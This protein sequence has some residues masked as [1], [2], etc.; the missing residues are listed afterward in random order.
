MATKAEVEQLRGDVARL[1]DELTSHKLEFAK[2]HHRY[3]ETR[4]ELAQWVSFAKK[5]APPSVAEEQPPAR[6]DA[7]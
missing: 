6:E 4:L 2:L 3:E 5:Y 7:Q 1:T